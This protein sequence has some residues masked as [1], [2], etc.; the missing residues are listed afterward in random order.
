M[1]SKAAAS[2]KFAGEFPANILWQWSWRDI[3][4][5]GELPWGSVRASQPLSLLITALHCE[6]SFY[7][8]LRG[9]LGL[10]AA[11]FDAEF[12]KSRVYKQVHDDLTVVSNLFDVSDSPRVGD[13][14]VLLVAEVPVIFYAAA[15]DV[16]DI[17]AAI[18]RSGKYFTAHVLQLDFIWYICEVQ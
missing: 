5:T 9:A 1:D 18:L 17:P 15:W 10:P 3:S 2:G 7:S 6:G 16:K 8:Q 4:Q 12:N 11:A 14:Y 13:T